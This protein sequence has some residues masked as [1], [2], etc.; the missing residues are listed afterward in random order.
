MDELAI[1]EKINELHTDVRVITTKLEVLQH[2]LENIKTK[3]FNMEEKKQIFSA[4]VILS[5]I[6]GFVG[7]CLAF[8]V[9]LTVGR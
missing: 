6:S 9:E 1:L 5:L 3:V 7:I 4:K 2:D 8:L